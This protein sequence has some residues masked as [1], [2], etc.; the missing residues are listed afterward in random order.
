MATNRIIE[1]IQPHGAG[2]DNNPKP[3]VKEPTTINMIK[4]MESDEV[5]N[6]GAPIKKVRKT[7][8]KSI[9]NTPGKINESDKK[10]AHRPFNAEYELHNGTD[11]EVIGMATV[12]NGVITVLAIDDSADENYTGHALSILLGNIIREADLSNANLVLELEDVNNLQHVRFLER[13]GF[14]RTEKNIMKRNAGSITP[15]T[16]QSAK[17]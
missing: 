16:V 8:K 6:S 10:Y 2:S 5:D 11:G 15:T 17:I 3:S 9:T 13:F 1:G 12:E 4:D 14:R 7:V